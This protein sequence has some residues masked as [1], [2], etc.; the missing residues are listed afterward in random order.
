MTSEKDKL[1]AVQEWCTQEVVKI[2][3]QL[4]KLNEQRREAERELRELDQLQADRAKFQEILDIALNWP[5][6][7]EQM[8]GMVRDGILDPRHLK[9]SRGLP[10]KW[11]RKNNA[12]KTRVPK[13]A[14]KPPT[15]KGQRGYEFVS[16][17][18]AIQKA[19]KNCSV[20]QA[21]RKL[22]KADPSKWRAK[23]RN[24]AR[25]FSEMKKSGIKKVWEQWFELETMLDTRIQN[26][27]TKTDL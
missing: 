6:N 20:A 18:L 24:L 22:K 9:S 17:V 8:E 10:V 3:Q 26:L 13:Y 25:R 7:R 23:P 27:L 14:R 11:G 15:W 5:P 21:I 19:D 12:K 4:A 1:R 2:N 16:G